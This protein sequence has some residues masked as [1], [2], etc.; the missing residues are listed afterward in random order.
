MGFLE[1]EDLPVTKC[2]VLLG[3]G[4]WPGSVGYIPTCNLVYQCSYLLSQLLPAPKDLSESNHT[5]PQHPGLQ[6]F[7]SWKN[8]K[9]VAPSTAKPFFS[10]SGQVL[11]A[12]SRKP[13]RLPWPSARPSPRCPSF[14]QPWV[15][16]T[17]VGCPTAAGNWLH[18]LERP[19]E[20]QRVAHVALQGLGAGRAL[21][22]P[23]LRP[24]LW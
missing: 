7:I 2:H 14:P 3:L 23:G 13:L 5:R 16:Q 24:A 10:L 4:G 20:V 15:I 8:H 18:L 11:G 21:S 12:T 17:G 19:F 1:E 9:G 22:H 6:G